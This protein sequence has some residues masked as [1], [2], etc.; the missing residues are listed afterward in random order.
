MIIKD[1]AVKGLSVINWD[2]FTKDMTPA[3]IPGGGVRNAIYGTVMITLVAT[4]VGVPIGLLTGVYLSEY[5]RHSK[6][7][8]IVRFTLNVLMGIP[9]ILIGVFFFAVFIV[10]MGHGSGY[11]GGLALAVIM[12]PIVAKTTE[13]MLLLVPDGVREA[14]LALGAP[15][16][17][18]PSPSCSATPSQA[19]LRGSSW[20]WPGSP[21]R[22][23]P[24]SSRPASPSSGPTTSTGKPPTSP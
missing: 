18:S 9:S 24:L 21:A 10:S 4:L 15:G 5:G 16:G 17:V 19:L 22:R 11:V 8:K 14:A 20:P 3:G 12:I 13:E 7:G 6:F 1:V 2:F 23:R